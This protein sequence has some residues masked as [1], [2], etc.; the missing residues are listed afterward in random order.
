MKASSSPAEAGPAGGIA[1]GSAP[2]AGEGATP[3]CTGSEARRKTLW[4]GPRDPGTYIYT[5]P[6]KFIGLWTAVILL[7][8]AGRRR[9]LA[10]ARRQTLEPRPT[11]VNEL[12]ASMAELVTRTVGPGIHVEFRLGSCWRVTHGFCRTIPRAPC[13]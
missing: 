2:R 3:C 12:V 13:R 11:D 1:G 10:F 4:T 9:L 7:D 5:I 8:A 6:T